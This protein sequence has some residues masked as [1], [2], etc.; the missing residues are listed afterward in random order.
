MQKPSGPVVRMPGALLMTLAVEPEKT[1]SP[2]SSWKDIFVQ[3][4]RT[5]SKIIHGNTNSA[6]TQQTK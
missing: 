2:R 6:V 4:L 3:V 5:P 1:M